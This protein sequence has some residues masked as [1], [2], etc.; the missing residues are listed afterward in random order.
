MELRRGWIKHT[1]AQGGANEPNHKD[2]SGIGVLS[3]Y[4]FCFCGCFSS[5][6]GGHVMFKHMFRQVNLI[7]KGLD[8]AWLRQETYSHNIANV[9]TPGYKTKHVQFEHELQKAMEG[10][11]MTGT[12]THTNHFKIGVND[13][14]AVKPAIMTENFHTMRLDGNNVDIDREMTGLAINTITY[15]TLANQMTSEFSRLRTAIQGN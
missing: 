5:L 2:G 4:A 6:E 7:Q 12:V 9:D 13:P 1:K 15:N 14:L 11:N 8:V 3:R 10:K